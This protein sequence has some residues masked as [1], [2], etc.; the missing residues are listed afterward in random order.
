MEIKKIIKGNKEYYYLVHS[1]R[2]GKFV[3][4]KQMY[5]GDSVPKN[6]D[7][8]KKDFMQDFYKEKFLININKI[9]ENFNKQKKLMPES[10]IEKQKE[11]FAIRFTY[12][13]QRIEG[14]TLTLKDTADLL[15]RGITPN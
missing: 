2:E 10:A 9:K 5:L 7:K 3:R 1:Y 6:I 4:K 8:K 15:E 11:I 14:S 12:N 13:S